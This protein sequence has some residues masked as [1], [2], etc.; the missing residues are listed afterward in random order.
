MRGDRNQEYMKDAASFQRNYFAEETDIGVVRLKENQAYWRKK[1]T[2][3]GYISD[4][5]ED[6]NDLFVGVSTD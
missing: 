5:L 3:D 6:I 4:F 2:F 1:E